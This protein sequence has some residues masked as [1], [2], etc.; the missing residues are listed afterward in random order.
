MTTHMRSVDFGSHRNR[1]HTYEI[2][3]IH[4]T[5]QSAK[6]EDGDQGHELKHEVTVNR[7]HHYY[8]ARMH[9]KAHQAFDSAKERYYDK[10]QMTQRY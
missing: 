5:S 3:G 9:S 7:F 4:R 1:L 8:Q 10:L 2:Y 6:A